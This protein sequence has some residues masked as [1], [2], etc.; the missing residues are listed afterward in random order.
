MAEHTSDEA[1]DER[2]FSIE[3]KAKEAAGAVPGTG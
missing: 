2:A 1:R 3:G